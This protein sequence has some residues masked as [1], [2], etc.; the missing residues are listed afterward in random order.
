MIEIDGYPALVPG[1]TAVNGELYEVGTTLLAQL[2][3]FE[4]SGYVRAP[5]KLA[6]G[7]TAFAY[8]LADAGTR[9]LSG[10]AR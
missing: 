10:D 2:D 8:W 7:S 4:G 1:A 9:S 3:A 6:D 5:V